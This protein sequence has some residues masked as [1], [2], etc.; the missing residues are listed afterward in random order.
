MGGAARGRV[1]AREEPDARE[2][3]RWRGGKGGKVKAEGGK[4][5]G[6]SGVKAA[7]NARQRV[8]N[9]LK[10]RKS[11]GSMGEKREKKRGGA[12]FVHA[13]KKTGPGR[14]ASPKRPKGRAYN[15]N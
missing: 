8:K 5:K 2:R 12:V 3:E 14:R 4:K 11:A 13:R 9:G 1:G 7:Q 10:R 6:K 15:E